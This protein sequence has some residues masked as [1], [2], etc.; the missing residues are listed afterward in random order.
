[1]AKVLHARSPAHSAVI[2][3][4]RCAVELGSEVRASYQAEN[5]IG[6]LSEFNPE[7]VLLDI[8]M[9]H[10]D[11]YE[12]PG[13]VRERKGSEV[14]AVVLTGWGQDALRVPY[15]CSRQAIQ[16]AGECAA[17]T[18]T[19]RPLPERAFGSGKTWHMHALL[20][21]RQGALTTIPGSRLATSYSSSA[22]RKST[23]GSALLP[24]RS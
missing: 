7:L 20:A 17:R 19:P 6:L 24:D 15:A 21:L 18:H 22:V 16:E 4:C 12:A 8:G 2:G 9:P 14:G 23:S 3:C 1:M 10:I 5:A 11:R 13:L